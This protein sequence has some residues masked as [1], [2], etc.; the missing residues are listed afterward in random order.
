MNSLSR[1]AAGKAF[2]CTAHTGL[3]SLFFFRAGCKAAIPLDQRPCA[4]IRLPAKLFSSNTS[5]PH[6]AG[7]PSGCFSCAAVLRQHVSGFTL[8]GRQKI[9]PSVSGQKKTPSPCLPHRLLQGKS[10]SLPPCGKNGRSSAQGMIRHLPAILPSAAESRNNAI[11]RRIP[12]E[13]P[14]YAP[15]RSRPWQERR[16]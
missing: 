11:F 14:R 7:S 16:S 12:R 5:F 2:S 13:S 15:H 6:S 10:A 9:L 1:P 4:S 8:L 3:P